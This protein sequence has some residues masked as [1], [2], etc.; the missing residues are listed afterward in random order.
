MGRKRQKPLSINVRL[1]FDAPVT[2]A[3]ARRAM[4]MFVDG[5]DATG[6]VIVDGIR[7]RVHTVD[8]Q[9]QGKRKQQGDPEDLEA[10]RAI[11]YTEGVETLRAGAV[12]RNRL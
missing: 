2:E 5:E 11:L 10:F 9:T 3:Q 7:A 12:K 8:W 6:E 4:K 1:T